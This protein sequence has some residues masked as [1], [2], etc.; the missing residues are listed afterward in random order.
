MFI[1]YV[2]KAKYHFCFV[3]KQTKT[4]P[5]EYIISILKQVKK[6]KSF[7]VSKVF[8]SIFHKWGHTPEFHSVNE[9]WIDK[10]LLHFYS[11]LHFWLDICYFSNRCKL[12]R[13]KCT[14]NINYTSAITG[15]IMWHLQTGVEEAGFRFPQPDY[16]LLSKSP[17]WARNV[18][19]LH[20]HSTVVANSY[21]FVGSKMWQFHIFSTINSSTLGFKHIQIKWIFVFMYTQIFPPMEGPPPIILLSHKRGHLPGVQKANIHIEQRYFIPIHACTK[22]GA[23]W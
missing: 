15:M 10:C 16:C 4:Q 19:M 12:P 1:S 9:L 23:R 14:T 22:M 18:S 21:G 2:I 7:I 3:L 5:L 17:Q 6:K 8:S 11:P 13:R 20:P